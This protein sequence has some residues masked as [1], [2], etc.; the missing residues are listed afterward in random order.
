MEADNGE[1]WNNIAAIHMQAGRHAMP[2]V[3]ALVSIVAVF[4]LQ[5]L[6]HSRLIPT[7]RSCKCSFTNVDFCC[8]SVHV[9][10][11]DVA[12]APVLVAAGSRPL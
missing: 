1:A 4:T 9:Y 7:M 6:R 11:V 12:K 2:S 3:L 10:H 8:Q 5:N